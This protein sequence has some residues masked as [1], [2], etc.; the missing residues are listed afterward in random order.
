MRAQPANGGS[1]GMSEKVTVCVMFPQVQESLES[2]RE[3]C[4]EMEAQLQ[5]KETVLVAV[6]NK[7]QQLTS[8]LQNKVCVPVTVCVYG[9]HTYVGL[10]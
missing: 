9:L 8:D 7:T 5:R 1:L 3:K 2:S 10:L 6:Q 4:R